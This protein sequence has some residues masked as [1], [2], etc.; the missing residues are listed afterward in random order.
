[1]IHPLIGSRS[2]LFVTRQKFE[3]SNV[4]LKLS[5]QCY[6]NR[7]ILMLLLLGK[8]HK[9]KF[10]KKRSQRSQKTPNPRVQKAKTFI[11][12][13]SLKRV[14]AVNINCRRTRQNSQEQISNFNEAQGMV[15]RLLPRERSLLLRYFSFDP[16]VKPEY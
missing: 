13:K 15:I 7:F 3:M 1:M 5:A 14:N 12:N 11:F 10:H 4:M 2:F 8:Y 9:F 6:S 16:C